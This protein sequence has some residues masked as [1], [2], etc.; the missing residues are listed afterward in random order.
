MKKFAGF[1]LAVF[2]IT[3]C[4]AVSLHAEDSSDE[5]GFGKPNRIYRN[6]LSLSLAVPLTGGFNIAWGHPL[7]D[8]LELQSF[9]A[10]FDR[11]WILIIEPS[12]W[13]SYSGYIGTALR[14]YPRGNST[15]SGGYFVGGDLGLAI[16]YQTYNPLDES[17]VFF[18][19]FIDFYLL[20]Y[21]FHVWEGLNIELIIGGG[22]A[23]VSQIVD[24]EGNT[25]KGG[26]FYPL[27]DFRISYRW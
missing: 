27:S 16:S 2:V 14:Y 10:Y 23:P 7:S 15:G 3:I 22:F 26:D 18:F 8:R 20:G 25:H 11:D 24:I 13:H 4:A 17:D 9:V 12:D 6:S 1:F 5:K 19:P 21:D